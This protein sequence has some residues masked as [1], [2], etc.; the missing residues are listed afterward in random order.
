[1]LDKN[2]VAVAMSGGV[3]SSVVAYLLKEKG[4]QVI[5][6]HMK[7]FDGIDDQVEKDFISVCKELDIP[8]HVVDLRDKFKKD[9]IDY[10][11]R[12][13][14]SGNTPNPC[15][16]CNKNIKF[17]VMLEET[18]KLGAYY[19][20]TGHYAKIKKDE[21]D[22]YYIEKANDTK[23]DQTYMFYTLDQETLKH[24]MMPLGEFESK[25]KV[26]ELAKKIDTKVHRKKD[27]QEICFITNDDYVDF[28]IKQGIKTKNGEFIDIDGSV[29][30]KHKGIIHYTIGQR[31]G[32]GVSFGKPMYVV[33]I[34]SKDKKVIL[35]ENKDLMKNSLIAKNYNFILNKYSINDVI[36]AKAKIRYSSKE[37]DCIIELISEFK[38]KVTFK[39]PQ[40]A[41]TPGQSVVFYSDNRMIGGA[42]IEK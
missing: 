5:G 1:M 14:Q 28:L 29:L 24:V 22:E 41:V 2:K 37:E 40:R 38:L 32:L 30:G 20:A 8:Y 16:V 12:E 6:L 23:K 4:M 36:N 31:K 27:S 11:T 17:G 35:G 39:N 10:F 13:Y 25:E 3:D 18:K 15:V 19:L 42:V 34:N 26:R 33:G 9:V 21:N 7:V